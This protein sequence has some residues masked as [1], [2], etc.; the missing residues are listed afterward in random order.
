MRLIGKIGLFLIF[1]VSLYGAEIKVSS[2][3]IVKGDAVTFEI[4]ANGSDI[5]FPDISN[6]DGVRVQGFGMGINY[7]YKN[8]KSIK[9]K[10]RKYTFY[11]QKD[12][13]IPS[14][15]LKVDGKEQ[16][17]QPVQIK[18]VSQE[19]MNSKL[20]YKLSLH[21]SDESPIVGQMV[22]LGIEL[23]IDERLQVGDLKISSIS[24][25]DKF[26]ANQKPTQVT[27]NEN[28]YIVNKLNYWVTP[29]KDGNFTVGAVNVSIGM[30]TRNTDPFGSVFGG[31]L[32]YKTIKSNRVS[33]HVKPLPNGAKVAGDFT[34]KAVADSSSAKAGKPVNVII[35][36]QG[37]GNLEE[38][39]GFKQDINDVVI[40]DDKP[41]I[42]S[43]TIDDKYISSWSQKIAYIG[44]KDFVIAP[45][46][47]TFYDIKTNTIKTIKT[48]PIPV[49][50]AGK[51]EKSQDDK[52]EIIKPKEIKSVVK[53]KDTNW[54][55]I[56][57]SF[58]AGLAL[59]VLISKLQLKISLPKKSSIF[60]NDKEFL[61]EILPL[62]G[63]N[64]ELDNWIIKLE[65]NIYKNKN[66]HIDK[67]NIHNLIN[68][69]KFK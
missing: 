43:R 65:E 28:G 24:G 63:K 14:F 31:G 20:P 6:I 5:D 37:E 19:Q 2:S 3:Q 52:S 61:R 22:K 49:H 66:H 59:G 46:S 53:T 29:L 4:I 42:K 64:S 47:L 41:Q 67:K 34:I 32:R 54:L 18:I 55:W 27:T 21:V 25:M 17:T 56:F 36:I 44:S 69:L 8:G 11:P 26:W 9:I 58:I 15:R 62:K 51:I 50:V 48:E 45:F 23:K 13:L 30:V 68:I 10:S 33:L 40:Y 38:L 60:K 7:S 16:Y 39:E 12:T 57:I 35:Q 1:L